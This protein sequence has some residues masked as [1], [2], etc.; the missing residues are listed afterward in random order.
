MC[1]YVWAGW[2]EYKNYSKNAAHTTFETPQ[3]I[4]W[5]VVYLVA[6][7]IALVACSFVQ[8]TT[9]D[10]NCLWENIF[11]AKGLCYWQCT[12]APPPSSHI[13]SPALAD[14]IDWNWQ[15]CTCLHSNDCLIWSREKIWGEKR[16]TNHSIRTEHYG[17]VDVLIADATHDIKRYYLHNVAK[18]EQRKSIIHWS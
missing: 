5:I 16:N 9:H 11:Q 2:L 18:N 8:Y 17:T 1:V 7:K 4:K 3:W 13:T 6:D 10:A 12:A 15:A 14:E